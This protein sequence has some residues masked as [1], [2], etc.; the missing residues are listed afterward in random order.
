MSLHILKKN[1]HEATY[2]IIYDK[3][4]QKH[5]YTIEAADAA[6]IRFIISESAQQHLYTVS[7]MPYF[8]VSTRHDRAIPRESR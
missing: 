7:F 6:F 1:A 2:N 4:T 5:G 3:L 8:P